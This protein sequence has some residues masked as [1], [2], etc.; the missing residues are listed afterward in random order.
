MNLVSGTWSPHCGIQ[1]TRLSRITLHGDVGDIYKFYPLIAQYFLYF[2][3][4]RQW[5]PTKTSLLL[6]KL[7]HSNIF[8]LTTFS[9]F[10]EEL[11]QNFKSVK[12]ISKVQCITYK[13]T[14]IN[15][16]FEPDSFTSFKVPINGLVFC[17]GGLKDPHQLTDCTK[18][19]K[20]Q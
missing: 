12:Y 10:W 6:R 16:E 1:N 20:S 17:P 18:R 14:S 19:A 5:K 11:L 7:F 13:S 3:H 15:T 2:F 8:F 4:K 9:E